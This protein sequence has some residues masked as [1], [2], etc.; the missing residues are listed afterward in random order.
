MYDGTIITLNYN[1]AK[2]TVL[3]PASVANKATLA[4]MDGEYYPYSN[5]YYANAVRF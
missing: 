3:D 2:V 4:G 1:T 5:D